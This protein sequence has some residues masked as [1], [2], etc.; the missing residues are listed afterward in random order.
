[1]KRF[2]VLSLTLFIAL[3]SIAQSVKVDFSQ[4]PPDLE[5]LMPRILS[6]KNDSMR[7]YLVLS[8]LTI[9]ET[10]PVLD[11][12]NS[13][14]IMLAGNKV[15]DPICQV[16]GYGCLGYDYK[17]LGN[18]VKSLQNNLLANKIA[19]QS[20]DN[21]LIC[22]A[23]VF[24]ALNYLDLKDYDKAIFYNRA[25]L[26]AASKFEPNI[27]S[28]VSTLDM[29]AI[30]MAV[31]K[32]DSALIYTQKAYELSISTGISYWLAHIYM[33]LGYI[34]S[35]M[36][37]PALATTFMRQAIDEAHR[38]Q[39]PK[40]I[41]LTY[42]QMANFYFSNNQKD[43]AEYY[44]KRAISSVENSAFSTMTID[45]AKLLLDIYRDA[46][47]DS[48]FKYSEIYRIAQDSLYNIKTIQQAQLM[49]LEENTRQQEISIEK[50]LQ[51]NQ[52]K[53]NLQYS[54]I[55][56]GIFLLLIIYLL[57]SRSMIKSERLIRFIGVIALLIVFEFLNLLLHPILDKTTHHSPL[58]M[59][60]SLVCIAAVL[61]PLHHKIEKWAINKLVEKNKKTRIAEAK[62]TLEQLDGNA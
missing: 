22:F 39:S 30:Y 25:S 2:V 7:Y 37:T 45:P 59:L 46:N 34:H 35:I 13:E 53:T 17:A 33:Q 47:K 32:I 9:S 56:I 5:K 20:N 26:D 31:N 1:M 50:S 10:N 4:P 36:K 23:K 49:T 11:M 29:G 55:A 62:K 54:L 6:E 57:M 19:E 58:L 60:L 44:A 61:I 41:C 42:T 15:K 24:L 43:S 28:I 21:R 3:S 38:I 51:E 52:R 18:N 40:Y 14:K 8:A 12:Y 48:A 27:I 16:L